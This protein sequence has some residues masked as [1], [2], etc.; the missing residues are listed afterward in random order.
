MPIKH[1]KQFLL[2]K[3][4]KIIGKK[5][6]KLIEE[7]YYQKRKSLN[8]NIKIKAYPKKIP[9][10]YKCGSKWHISI[11]CKVKEIIDELYISKKLKPK[12]IKVLEN[13]E[14]SRSSDEGLEEFHVLDSEYHYTTEKGAN[15]STTKQI[16]LIEISLQNKTNKTKSG[17]ISLQ[18]KRP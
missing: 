6:Y 13:F 10:C 17:L 1:K 7:P 15:E 2:R 16:E 8:K 3:W 12:I 18:T 9:T 5:P 14:L 4:K 11:N